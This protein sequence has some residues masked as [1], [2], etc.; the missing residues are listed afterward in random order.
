MKIGTILRTL[1][2]SAGLSQQELATR[3]GIS[4]SFLSLLEADRREPTMRVLRDIGS[5]LGIPSEV[6]IVASLHSDES[7]SSP[8][9]RRIAESINDLVQAAHHFVL[10]ERINKRKDLLKLFSRED[11]KLT[12]SDVPDE[13]DS[14]EQP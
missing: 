13:K 14:N 1:R 3:V 6:L 5:A 2:V 12:D 9:E 11:S 4:A 7:A 8:E 10:A